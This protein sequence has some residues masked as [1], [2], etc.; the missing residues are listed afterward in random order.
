MDTMTVYNMTKEIDTLTI[1]NAALQVEVNNLNKSL[2]QTTG[3]LVGAS[4]VALALG[5]FNM[6][7]LYLFE[8][9]YGVDVTVE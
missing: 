7:E 8:D 6:V 2:K 1:K 5:I 9:R 4:I 3:L